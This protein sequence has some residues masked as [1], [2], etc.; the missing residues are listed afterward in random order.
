MYK[1]E[2]TLKQHTPIIHFQH[3]Q[4]GATLRATE[5][6]PKLDRFLIEKFKLTEIDSNQKEVPK[7]EFKHYF[8][9]GGKQHLALDYKVR[10]EPN[11]SSTYYLPLANSL[12]SK[13]YPNKEAN[14][15]NYIQSHIIHKF[16]FQYLAPTPFFSNSDKIKF[17][18]QSD[19]VENINVKELEFATLEKSE[20]QCSV[21]SYQLTLIEKISESIQT[22]FVLQNFGKRQ[23]KGFGSY[24]ILKINNRNT[25]KSI[26]ELILELY[27]DTFIVAGYKN[28]NKLELNKIFENID[29]VWKI[30]KS[31][32]NHNGYEKS[33]LFNYFYTKSPKVRWEKRAIKKQIKETYPDVFS[34][35]KY[36]QN[37]PENRILTVEDKENTH[38][39]LRGL[40]GLAEY[41]EFGTKNSKDKVLVKISDALSDSENA[42]NEEMAI[43]RFKAPITFKII[44]NSIYLLVFKIPN[45]L[46]FSDVKQKRKFNFKLKSMI[47]N[48]ELNESLES[49]EMPE[50]FKVSEFLD[51][52]KIETN[53]GNATSESVAKYHGFTKITP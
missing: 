22:F 25:L 37:S 9:N 3:D 7:G 51:S 38:F 4:E 41:F 11:K 40:L 35:L 29:E 2:F 33:D 26:N 5:L 36:D 1:L 12:Y 14:V 30:L 52:M 42:M 27:K 46:V 49:L 6:K 20:I 17:S 10:I 13:K 31:G 8:I 28:E 48:R 15:K 18:Q 21:Q 39:Y 45:D 34:A 16:D 24:S 32:K 43:D 47:N 44:E 50:Y 53:T 19:Q 23:N